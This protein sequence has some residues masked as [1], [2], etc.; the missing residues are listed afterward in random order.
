[1]GNLNLKGLQT[2]L[3]PEFLHPLGFRSAHRFD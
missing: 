1:M 3:M 2:V